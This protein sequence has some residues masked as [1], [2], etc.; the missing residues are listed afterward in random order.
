MFKKNYEQTV[1]LRRGSIK[2]E[3]Y[4]KQL[5]VSFK[6]Y[7]DFEYIVK[8]IKN[9]DRHDRDDNTSYTE[10]NQ[11]YI[12]FS[13]AYKVVWVDDKFS[14]LIVFYRG[15]NAPY[16]FIKAIPKEYGYCRG[17]TKKHF[18]KNLVTSVRDEQI[19][20]SSNKC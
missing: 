5:V 14:K 20:Q 12:P 8:R 13:F 19:F 6:I 11:K 18:N 4:F 2:F 9:S 15:K 3:N 17:V 10:K 1:R 16:R 7:A